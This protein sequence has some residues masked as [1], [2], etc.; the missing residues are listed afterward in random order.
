M[1]QAHNHQNDR[2]SAKTLDS[3]PTNTKKVFK[4]QK[5]ASVM[6][7]TAISEKGKSLL[8][9]FVPSGVKINKKLYK[10]DILKGALIPWYKSLYGEDNWTLQDGATSYTDV[11]T[12][13][14]CES[15]CPAWISNEKWPPSSPDLIPLDYSLWSVFESEACSK[16]SP[17]IE[18]LKLKLMKTWEKIPMERVRAFKI[19]LCFIL[20]QYSCPTLYF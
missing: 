12:E 1:Q 17:S 20:L 16:P 10:K 19:Y 8:V 3:I 6:V 7:W 9:F 11:V 13:A 14:W 4:T 15:D 5:P 2:V 18:A